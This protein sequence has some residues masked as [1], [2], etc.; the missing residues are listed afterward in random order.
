MNYEQK[1]LVII[2]PAFPA[3]ETEDYWV[4]SQQLLTKALRNNFPELNVIVLAYFYPYKKTA[5]HW[6]GVEVMSFNG[7]KLNRLVLLI[8]MWRELKKLKRENDILGIL[9]FWCREGAF[10]GKWFS[11]WNGLK[12]FCWIC[13]QDARKTNKWV[14]WVVPQS[15]ELVAISDF[16]QNEFYENHRIKPAHVIPNAI[17]PAL[18]PADL[19]TTRN[20]DV[21]AVGSLIPLK[22][23]DVFVSVMQKLQQPL[24]GIKAIICGDGEEK[25]TLRLLIDKYELSDHISLV[26]ATTQKEVLKLMQQTKIFL[27]PASYEG[28]STVCLE[29]LYAGAKVISFTKPMNLEIKN[30]YIAGSEEEMVTKSL[31]LLRTDNPIYE[32]VLVYEMNKNA[33]KMMQLFDQT[34]T[35]ENC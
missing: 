11:K 27:H 18:F 31:E 4:P 35:D 30:W 21:L 32:R 1:T 6:R 8:R 28:F 20:I 14:R 13:G 19:P 9:S 23:F 22:R 7:I 16:I 12:H 34:R 15:S 25:E 24:P 17:E 5:Y 33:K 3:N 10:I 29:A 2:S 26:D